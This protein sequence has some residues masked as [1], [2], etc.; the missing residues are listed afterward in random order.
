MAKSAA[1]APS[2]SPAWCCERTRNPCTARPRNKCATIRVCR[3]RRSGAKWWTMNP[4][5]AA[6]GL[7][8]RG[9]ACLDGLARRRGRNSMPDHLRTGIAG[10]DAAFFELRR[11]GYIVVARRWSAGNLN[12][13]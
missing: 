11:K 3:T 1:L 4:K 8:E 7:M 6:I 10:E 9:L 13:D 12:G 5:H 2:R